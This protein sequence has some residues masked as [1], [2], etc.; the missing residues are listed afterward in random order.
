MAYD[1]FTAF[2]HRGWEH[3]VQPYENYFVRLTAQSH[4]ALLDALGV[5]DASRMLDVATGPGTLAA[6][7][8]ERG[9]TVSGIDFSAAMIAHARQT[10]PEVEFQVASADKL[11]FNDESFDAVGIAFGML[12][13][14]DPEAALAEAFRVL[15]K[16][17]R[18]AFT[19][20]AAPEKAIGFQMVLKAVEMHGR[21]DVALPAGP[22]FFRFS[23]ADES[24]SVLTNAGFADPQ[25]IEVEQTWHIAPP[26]TPFHSLLRGGV[27]MSALLNAQEPPALLKIESEVKASVARYMQNGQLLVPM[28]CVLASA[29]KR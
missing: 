21:M 25:V 10:Y 6:A 20:W 13:F 28:P 27:R 2:E 12:H 26:E 22:P 11:P 8:I 4:G 9:A 15:R 3:L 23:D 7:A 5:G 16:G 24:K 29:V 1:D 19:V 17:G 18:V 14:P